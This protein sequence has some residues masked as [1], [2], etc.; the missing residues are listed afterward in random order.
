MSARE[1]WFSTCGAVNVNATPERDPDAEWTG[2]PK[3]ACRKILR[4]IDD[5]CERLTCFDVQYI[6]GWCRAALK[7]ARKEIK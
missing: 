6:Q 5:E 7:Q 1:P 2:T 3:Q 4:L